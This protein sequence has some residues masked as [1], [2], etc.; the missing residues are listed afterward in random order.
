L[1]D[2]PFIIEGTREQAVVHNPLYFHCKFELRRKGNIQ[3]VDLTVNLCS[4]QTANTIGVRD[5]DPIHVDYVRD[6][7]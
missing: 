2:I 7:L 4:G 5:D 3:D 1:R 6:S